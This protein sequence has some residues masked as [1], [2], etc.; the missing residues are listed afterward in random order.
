MKRWR[1]ERVGL[2]FPKAAP[3]GE[4]LMRSEEYLW[5]RRKA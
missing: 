5:K 4:N 1:S 3:R 2:K